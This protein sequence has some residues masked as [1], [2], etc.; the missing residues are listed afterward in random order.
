MFQSVKV[1]CELYNNYCKHTKDELE[2]Y[3]EKMNDAFARSFENH[4][5][6]EKRDSKILLEFRKNEELAKIKNQQYD[7]QCK[8]YQFIKKISSLS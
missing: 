8:M 2:I 6:D 3:R 4:D 7:K 5:F 1:I